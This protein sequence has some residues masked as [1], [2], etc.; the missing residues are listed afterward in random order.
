[1]TA[2]PRTPVRSPSAVQDRRDAVSRTIQRAALALFTR[3][4][5]DAVSVDDVAAAA[6]ISQRT[7]FRYFGSKDDVLLDYQRRLD[8]RLLAALRARPATEGAVTAL[9]NAFL[10]TSAV[11]PPDHAD[12]LL[13]ARA[14]ADAPG[15]RARSRGE[16]VAGAAALAEVL[17]ERMGTRPTDRRPVTVAAAMS[18]VARAAWD[19]WVAGGGADDPAEEIGQA[20]ALV[21]QGLDSLN[22]LRPTEE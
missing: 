6:G 11:A 15:L 18:A 22:R 9:R 14:L 7:F 13:R 2:A 10:E 19:Q 8:E 17:A 3:H 16:Q 1:V 20:L 21:E 4:G 12:V 5:F